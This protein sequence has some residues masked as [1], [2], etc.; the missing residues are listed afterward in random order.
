MNIR[1]IDRTWTAEAS[2]FQETWLEIKT[3]RVYTSPV[4]NLEESFLRMPDE[5]QV[6]FVKMN[7]GDWANVFAFTPE[8]ELILVEQWRLGIKN[9]S[10]ETPGGVIEAGEDILMGAKRELIEET[11]WD[12]RDFRHIASL[13]P[14]P[15]FLT[16]KIHFFLA[17]DCF[18][19]KA[20]ELDE[21]ERI[22]VCKIALTDFEALVEQGKI[23]HALVVAGWVLIKKYL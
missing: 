7:A 9:L 23:E 11:G 1:K 21:G 2:P 16:N 5:K 18:P 10:L 17:K 19:S 14:N 13:N 20:Q 15:A 22:K 4:M 3:D 6:K 12:S 8:K